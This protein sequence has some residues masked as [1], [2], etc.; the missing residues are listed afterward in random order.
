MK[1]VRPYR[2]LGR[3]R[4]EIRKVRGENND[5]NNNNNNNNDNNVNNFNNKKK[6]SLTAEVA[7]FPTERNPSY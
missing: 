7:H 2:T 1:S 6:K 4:K 3:R 5:N